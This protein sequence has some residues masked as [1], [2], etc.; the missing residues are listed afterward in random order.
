MPNFERRVQREREALNSGVDRKV[1][2]VLDAK[3]I[4]DRSMTVLGMN[5]MLDSSLAQKR[6]LVNTVNQV[7]REKYLTLEQETKLFTILGWKFDCGECRRA[8]VATKFHEKEYFLRLPNDPASE[9]IFQCSSCKRCDDSDGVPEYGSYY[10]QN[11]ERDEWTEVADAMV[12][13]RQR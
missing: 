1:L 7:R 8:K 13:L 3:I 2:E 10:Q 11:S 5:M 12:R 4:G 6:S 9:P